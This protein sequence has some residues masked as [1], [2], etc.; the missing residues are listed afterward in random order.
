MIKHILQDGRELDSIQGYKV[1]VTA[2][3]ERAYKLI[4]ETIRKGQTDEKAERRKN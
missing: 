1:P 4:S 3:T 2:A